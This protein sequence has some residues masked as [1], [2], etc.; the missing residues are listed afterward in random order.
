[1]LGTSFPSHSMIAAVAITKRIAAAVQGSIPSRTIRVAS[2]F[3]PQNRAA[4]ALSAN[5]ALLRGEEPAHNSVDLGFEL[6]VRE[7]T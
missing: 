3:V 2:K 1:M 4:R 7:S 5:A 6:T